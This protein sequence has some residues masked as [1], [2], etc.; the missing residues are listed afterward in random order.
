VP[1]GR[2]HGRGKGCGVV[3]SSEDMPGI[4]T[5]VLDVAGAILGIYVSASLWETWS[6]VTD[7]SNRLGF[8]CVHVGAGP[9]NHLKV[10]KENQHN[11][12]F[13]CI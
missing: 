1:C 8:I 9:C 3:A 7:R 5:A 2:C 11:P 12:S 6:K 10:V 13:R 4:E